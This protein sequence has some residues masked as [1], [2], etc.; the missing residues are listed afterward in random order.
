MI[1]KDKIIR[2]RLKYPDKVLVIVNPK[3][4]SQPQIKKNKFLVPFDI[5]FC[6]FKITVRKYID[7]EEHQT[8]L[9]FANNFLPQSHST[10]SELDKLY[11]SVDKNILIFTYSLES[12]FG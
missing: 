2:I 1:S 11:R 10:I 6:Q 8:L 3:N 7:L 5:P 9:L 4:L 12:T